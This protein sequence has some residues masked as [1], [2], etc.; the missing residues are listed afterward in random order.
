MPRIIITDVSVL[1]IPLHKDSGNAPYL[2][3]QV[4]SVLFPLLSRPDVHDGHVLLS[5]LFLA[6]DS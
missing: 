5:T 4:L 6:S 2:L 1:F 3:R